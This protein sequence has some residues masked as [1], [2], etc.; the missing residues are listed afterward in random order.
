MPKKTKTFTFEIT[1]KEIYRD[2]VEIEAES[3]DAAKK[4]LEKNMSERECFYDKV[5]E[6]LDDQHIDYKRIKN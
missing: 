2:T 1:I 5:T 4:Y 6:C 3:L